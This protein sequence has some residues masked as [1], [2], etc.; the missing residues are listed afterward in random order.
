MNLSA[1]RR[2]VQEYCRGAGQTQKTLAV[3]LGISYTVLSKK[4]NGSDEAR[5]SFPE[6]KQII[7]ILADWE[8]LTNQAQVL[9]L[10]E[11]TDCLN[12]SPQEWQS[13]P[14]NKLEATVSP[15]QPPNV[16]LNKPAQPPDATPTKPAVS[17]RLTNRQLQ[18]IP[19]VPETLTTPLRQPHH[20]LPAQPTPLIGRKHEIEAAHNL[21]RRADVRLV[22]LLGPGGIGKT[23][24]ALG[25]ASALMEDFE[26]GV[27]FVP[28]ASIS[29]PDLVA[30]AVLRALELDE[31]FNTPG[32]AKLLPQQILE[33]Y[34][35]HRR[36]LLVLDNFEQ[37]TEAAGGVG[38]LLSAAPGLKIL[39]TSRAILHLYGEYQLEVSPLDLPH[40]TKPIELEECSHYEAVQLFIQRARAV[41]PDFALTNANAPYIVQLCQ[42][43]EGLPLA[44]ELTA[45]RTRLFSPQILLQKLNEG[46]RLALL[47][48][49]ANNL[50]ARQKTLRATLEW[51]Y[52]LLAAPQ[53]QLFVA[54][55]VFVGNF[56][57]EAVRAV[58][59]WETEVALERMGELIDQSM[60][61]QPVVPAEPDELQFVMLE[62]LREYALEQLTA[63]GQ[64]EKTKRQH[65]H[66]YTQLAEKAQPQLR[67]ANYAYWLEQLETAHLN[68]LAALDWAVS[69]GQQ[70]D[71][72]L[73][74][75]M[76]V[77]LRRFWETRH[78]WEG[79][80][81]TERLV[82]QAAQ[83]PAL[84]HSRLY[85]YILDAAG[86][87]AW[88]QPDY[89]TAHA[90]HTQALTLLRELG[91]R[92]GQADALHRLATIAYLQEDLEL[93]QTWFDECLAL[94]RAVGDPDDLAV[95]LNNMGL[96]KRRQGQA[97]E[98]LRYYQEAI[99][100]RRQSGNLLELAASLHNIGLLEQELE[101]Y[102]VAE[103][104]LRE[105]MEIETRLGSHLALS[106][107]I[108]NLSGFLLLRG[109][110]DEAQTLAEA[111]LILAQEIGNS[112]GVA[113]SLTNLG[114]VALQR[115]DYPTATAWLGQALEVQQTT[116]RQ[117]F[118]AN[119]LERCAGAAVA[120]SAI[121]KA[122]RL[123]GAAHTIRLTSK[124][125]P[126]PPHPQTIYEH[127][128][129]KARASLSES[130]WTA[131]FVEG[132]AM[133]QEQA[134]TYALTAPT[135]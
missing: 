32:N 121:S 103:Y 37:L 62:T 102:Q 124:L 13:A 98:A 133:T 110:L 126:R 108:T 112:S 65:L 29:E 135:L 71:L 28:L 12:F 23:R 90:Y 96:L 14:L 122:V 95:T 88:V 116:G 45:A 100:L 18:T 77:A 7:K 113:A 46:S 47:T 56:T 4:L 67:K 93:A 42:R 89:P 1:F 130:E 72:E 118:L 22:T 10:L 24:L 111:G 106:R 38:D 33:R 104:H 83:F 36:M 19:T 70:S 78:I 68:V 20:Y 25:V 9:D 35:R 31:I 8:G 128:V 134:V 101:N 64:L 41:R 114:G 123:Y 66:Y 49:G 132:A 53:Q 79:R 50:P 127:L 17:P 11:L 87:F 80:K 21:L 82:E 16:K 59:G 115:G 58:C 6:I 43:L 5:L 34:L 91:D 86:T 74:L 48:G 85:G 54:L 120:M 73:A 55:G 61:S 117:G 99:L 97:V 109:K 26:D 69:T 40:Q 57:L 81:Q 75:A 39:V 27:C 125:T 51:S 3:R 94:R 60:L 63:A 129:A 107:A 119:A 76:A 131:L 92:P 44:I 2:L 105:S 15:P 84:L 52:K 30:G